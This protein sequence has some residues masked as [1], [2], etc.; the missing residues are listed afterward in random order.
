MNNRA[1]AT[2]E[3]T[4]Y[5][6]E[7]S[8]WTR[9]VAV[10]VL[11]VGL[12]M[13]AILFG[14]VLQSTILA[15]LLAYVL[16]FPVRFLTRR[17]RLPYALAALLVFLVYLVI[18]IALILSLAPAVTNFISILAQEIQAGLVELVKFLE[19]YTPDQGWLVNDNTSQ[20]IA[21]L[22]FIYQPLSNLVKGQAG[23]QNVEGLVNSVGFVLGTVTGTIGAIG[24]ALGTGLLVNLLALIFLLEVPA[25]S[26]WLAK[27]LPVT[28]RREYGI[29]GERIVHKWN[30][31]FRATVTVAVVL[32]VL[33]G[34]QTALLGIPGAPI[35]GLLSAFFGF[36]P[37]LGGFLSIVTIS[38]VALL[39]G[40]TSLNLDPL[41]LA[42][43]AVGI[44]LVIQAII[45]N[46]VFPLLSGEAVALPL[47]GVVLGIV[48]GRLAGNPHPG[49]SARDR[50]ICFEENR[51]R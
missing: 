42:L 17:A 34:L 10:V 15:L 40:S 26:N 47:P 38:L 16:Y 11:L 37:I 13:A 21:N 41:L 20:R 12:V 1:E 27:I 28:Y 9:R 33:N 24:A 25:A 31:Y 29:L 35:V 7:W 4:T 8:T 2:S 19:T 43:L 14:P 5:P 39:Q 3:T 18:V 22:N 32:G 50:G 45:W 48:A 46:V 51:R 44:N 36:I 23:E 30:S 6:A 49:Y